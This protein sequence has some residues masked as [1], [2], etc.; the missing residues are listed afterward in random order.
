MIKNWNWKL[1]LLILVGILISFVVIP[2][3]QIENFI[4]QENILNITDKHYYITSIGLEGPG[5]LRLYILEGS[6]RFSV[7]YK[8]RGCDYSESIGEWKLYRVKWISEGDCYS[9]P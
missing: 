8:E 4:K 5:K 2:F 6:I 1:L 7:T 9:F 3:I